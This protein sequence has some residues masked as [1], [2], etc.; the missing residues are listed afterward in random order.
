MS[1]P[2][3]VLK[4]MHKYQHKNT[5]RPE[6]QPHQ[7]NPTEYGNNIQ[8]LEAADATPPFDKDETKELMVI[9]GSLL[10]LG[11][12]IGN[13]LLTSLSNLATEKEKGNKATQE[14]AKKLLHY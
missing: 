1:I 6:H 10:F 12:A 13:N 4:S 11:R 2:G 3:Y 9:V 7:Y 5:S 8:Y 14:A